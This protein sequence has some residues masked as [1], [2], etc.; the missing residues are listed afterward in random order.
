MQRLTPF[1]LLGLAVLTVAAL[2][3]AGCGGKRTVTTTT[4]STTAPARIA[5]PVAG[6]ALLRG[7]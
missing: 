2:A 7:R 4:V 3:L 6:V 5:A 1:R